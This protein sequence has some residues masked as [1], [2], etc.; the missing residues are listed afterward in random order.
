MDDPEQLMPTDLRFVCGIIDSSDLP[1]NVSREI[2]QQSSDVARIRSASVK[3]VLS[4]LEGLAGNRAE[5]YATF[6]TEFGRVF[7][8]GLVEDL[9]N[10]ERL[11]KLLRYAS[12]RD[13]SAAQTELLAEYVGRMKEGQDTIYFI[14]A[15]GYATA[16]NSPHLEL[17]RKMGVEVLLM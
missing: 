13:D 12:T 16:K 2:L 10:K 8:E 9:P 7:K 11:A 1:V 4:L 14:T 17:F 6:W 15:D 5:K 3:R